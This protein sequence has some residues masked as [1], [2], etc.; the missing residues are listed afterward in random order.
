LEVERVLGCGGSEDGGSRG[1]R[2]KSERKVM[3]EI[4]ERRMA[5]D[6]AKQLAG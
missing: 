3:R 4:E 2:R 6:Q 5:R 1:K